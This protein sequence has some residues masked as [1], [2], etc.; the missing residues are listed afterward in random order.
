[1]ESSNGRIGKIRKEGLPDPLIVL[2]IL[3]SALSS[4]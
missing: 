3:S 2:L 4:R 1:M